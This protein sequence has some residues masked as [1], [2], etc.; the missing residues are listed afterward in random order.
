MV[1]LYKHLRAGLPEDQALQAAQQDLIAGP[2]EVT[3][4]QGER[5]LRVFS[6]PYYWAAVGR[7]LE[8]RGDPQ[9]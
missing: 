7:Q 9:F 3:N 5:A 2:I 6:A 8:L 4:D 1:R